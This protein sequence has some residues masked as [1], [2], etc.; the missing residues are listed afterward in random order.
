MEIAPD[1]S[2]VL[3][4]G[5]GITADSDIEA[6]WQECLHKAAATV[7]LTATALLAPGL[8]PVL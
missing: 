3:G 2:A 5:G 7:E 6:E 4:V 8:K 1:G